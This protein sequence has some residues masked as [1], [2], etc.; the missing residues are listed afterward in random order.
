[1]SEYVDIE[2][3]HRALETLK[4]C[5]HPEY[6]FY[7]PTDW[8][9]YAHRCKEDDPEGYNILYGEPS[10]DEIENVDVNEETEIEMIEGKRDIENIEIIESEGDIENI[11]IVKSSEDKETVDELEQLELEEEQYL[12]VDAVAKQQFEYNKN[13][14][15][16]ND[17][18]ELQVKIQND[19]ISLAPGE[20]TFRVIIVID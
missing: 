18:P 17:F 11:E 3:M 10:D 2:K 14:C 20:G 7:E 5:G 1:M 4:N 15:L 19:P 6:E 8:N 12:K 16:A 9:T 13:I